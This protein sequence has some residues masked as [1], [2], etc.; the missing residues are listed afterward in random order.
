MLATVECLITPNKNQIFAL[1]KV[2]RIKGRAVATAEMSDSQMFFSSTVRHLISTGTKDPK[3][4]CLLLL[5]LSST[6][7]KNQNQ[8]RI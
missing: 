7:F 8:R 4:N 6:F 5:Q 2:A 3:L 1:Y